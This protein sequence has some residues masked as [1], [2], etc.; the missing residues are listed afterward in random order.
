MTYNGIEGLATNGEG[1]LLIGTAFG[2]LKETRPY[3]YQEMEGERAVDGG[4]EIRSPAGQSQTGKFSYGF[5]VTSYNPSYP[6]IIDPTLL[7]STYLRGSGTDRGRGIAV[8]GSGNAY[9][10]GV[11]GSTN[12]PTQNPYQGTKANGQDAFV[13]KL[14]DTTLAIGNPSSYKVTVTKVEMYNGA[15]WV[16][17]FSGTAQLDMVAEGTFPGIGDQSLPA[18]TY[19]QIRVTFNNSFPVAGMVSYAAASYY[20]TATTFGGYTNLAGTPTTVAG[21]MAEFTFRIEAWGALDAD[22]VRGSDI[23]P[24]TKG[25][26]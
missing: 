15:S 21:S 25:K 16:T 11:T 6:L 4:F 17:I 2:E 12:F 1:E 20:T 9:V 18:G 10:T 24:V 3:I 26:R 5:Q 22:V 13:T 8:D 14:G 23:T 19:S 7:Y